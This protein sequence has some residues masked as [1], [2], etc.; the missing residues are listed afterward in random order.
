MVFADEPRHSFHDARAWTAAI[1]EGLAAGVYGIFGDTDARYRELL[2]IPDDFA[3]VA[4]VTLGHPLPDPEWSKV[5]SRA[6]QRRR[7]VD[8]IV[9]WNAWQS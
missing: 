2:H 7:T 4:G 3:I 8:D 1:D 6:T 9:H 5:T